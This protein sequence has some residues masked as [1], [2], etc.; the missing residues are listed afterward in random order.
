MPVGAVLPILQK[1]ESDAI[2]AEAALVEQLNALIGGQEIKPKAFFPIINAK[3]SYLIKGES[4]EAEVAIG[5]YSDQ[6]GENA[7]IMVNGQRIH[8]DAS[9][10][11]LYKSVATEYGKQT[12]NISA[13]VLNPFT[14]E[15]MTGASTYEYEVGERSV[16]ISLDKMNVL[17]IGLDNPITISAAGTSSNDLRVSGDGV[18]LQANGNNQYLAKV[19]KP[20][21]V[22]ISISGKD[23][24]AKKFHYIAKRIPTP[25]V[26][27]GS[28]TGTAIGNG[29]LRAHER[30]SVDM[31]SFNYDA[32]CEIL[33]FE[34][35]R[36]PSRN[37]PETCLN[38]SASFGAQAR[39]IIQ[40]ASPGDA[41]YFD[42]I[43]VK[44]PGDQSPRKVSSLAFRIK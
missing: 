25:A 15:L 13:S 26:K 7:S 17:Y 14:D 19:S 32:K 35:A 28:I 2:S 40:K 9:G 24:P 12:L 41:Y 29:T 5:T 10:K 43:K 4:F 11:G 6:F 21:K 36:K 33:G 37:D 44:C 23:L 31:G 8:L 16:A 27:L 22:S 3:K 34:L 18:Q 42:N 30:L 20:G 38:R 39:A 1:I